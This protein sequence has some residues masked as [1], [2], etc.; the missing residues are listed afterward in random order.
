MKYLSSAVDFAIKNWMLIIPVFVL[1]AISGLIQGAGAAASL[2]TILSLAD[3][4]NFTSAEAIFRLVP[5]ILALTV[6]SGIVAFIA[7]FIYEPATYGLV[8]KK[9]ETGSATLNEIGAAISENFVKYVMFFIGSLV[10]NLV[11]GIATVLIMLLMVLLVSLLKGFGV[12]L[13]VIVIIALVL[14]FLAFGV[15]ISLWFSAMVVDGLSVFDG[16]KKSIEIVRTCFWTVLG[17]TILVS[18]AASVVSAILGFL[19]AIPV[20]GPVILSVI[21]AAQY[22]V[23]AVFSLLIY[24]GKTG[25]AIA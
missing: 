23:I 10:V 21:P 7:R 18:L 16:F 12:A 13:M 8:N 2:G 19:G 9:L 6:G 17:I 22:F 11:L 20:L 3:M 5:T 4:D 1:L 14:F 15:L 24:R 25:R